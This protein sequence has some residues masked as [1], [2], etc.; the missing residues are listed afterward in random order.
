MD[1][2]VVSASPRADKSSMGGE[3]EDGDADGGVGLVCDGRAGVSS[4]S[5]SDW[6]SSS[7]SSATRGLM[8][9]AKR[10]RNPS[11]YGDGDGTSPLARPPGV[12]WVDTEGAGDDDHPVATLDGVLP[13][14]DGVAVA[15]DKG[16]I[17]CA[18]A[19]MVRVRIMAAVRATFPFIC[20]VCAR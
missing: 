18:A 5:V 13:A 11:G 2:R 15:A 10:R 19:A 8:D 16:D 9:F 3:D 4:K 20:N 17:I 6:A 14:T 12:L 7:E 1:A